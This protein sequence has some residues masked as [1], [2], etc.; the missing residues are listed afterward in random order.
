MDKK[1]SLPGLGWISSDFSTHFIFILYF[2]FFELIYFYGIL[3]YLLSIILL[4]MIDSIDTT[5]FLKTI[6]QPN[7]KF[8]LIFSV[9]LVLATRS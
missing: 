2:R 5:K 4:V 6:V 9:I 8:L 3:I 1:W 7:I